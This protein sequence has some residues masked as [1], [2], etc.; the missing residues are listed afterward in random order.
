M[1]RLLK[2]MYRLKQAHTALHTKISG[3]LIR[4][5]FSELISVSYVF[6]KWLGTGVFVLV[7]VYVSD[8]LMLSLV[9]G[10]ISRRFIKQSL[11]VRVSYVP[12]IC[13]D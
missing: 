13:K 4:M 3:D 5:G 6:I 2:A 1:K 12:K 10:D 8:F 11:H 9:V 7:L